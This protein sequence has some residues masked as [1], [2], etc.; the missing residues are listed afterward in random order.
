MMCSSV[1]TLN[2]VD[3]SYSPS[4]R[5]PLNYLKGCTKSRDLFRTGQMPIFP[6]AV[7]NKHGW[8]SKKILRLT[9]KL[10]DWRTFG[11][12]ACYINCSSLSHAVIGNIKI[13]HDKTTNFNPQG[14]K[15]QNAVKKTLYHSSLTPNMS[16][17]IC[18]MM[19][20]RKWNF[21]FPEVTAL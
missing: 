14:L 18:W 6:K 8:Y 21:S 10:T 15:E 16:Y 9:L 12:W 20:V 7:P 2:D 19:Q 11:Y 1:N 4:M 17:T 3:K 13:Y 5:V